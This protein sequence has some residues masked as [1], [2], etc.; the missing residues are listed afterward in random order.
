MWAG[1]QRLWEKSMLI[2]LLTGNQWITHSA[3]LATAQ[4]A[5]HSCKIYRT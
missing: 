3:S 2:N 4:W 5:N 1:T